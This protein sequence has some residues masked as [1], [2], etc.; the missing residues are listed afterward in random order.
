MK[1]PVVVVVVVVVVDAVVVETMV[2]VAVNDVYLHHPNLG[3]HHPNLH[4]PNLG[5]GFVD[6]LHQHSVHFL[7]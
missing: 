5:D 4:Y 7:L 6:Y 3:L 1:Q 2:F